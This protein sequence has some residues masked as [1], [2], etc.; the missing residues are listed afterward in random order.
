MFTSP[1]EASH[2]GCLPVQASCSHHQPSQVQTRQLI[3]LPLAWNP[4]GYWIE[5]V[6]ET[7][8][9]HLPCACSLPIQITRVPAC[10]VPIKINIYPGILKRL[11]FLNCSFSLPLRSGASCIRVIGSGG[12]P[13]ILGNGVRHVPPAPYI[14]CPISV[15]SLPELKGQSKVFLLLRPV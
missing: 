10:I 1:A 8:P 15:S 13:F 5:S 14:M 3:F 11:C 7:G 4:V 12:L 6:W 9:V 2:S